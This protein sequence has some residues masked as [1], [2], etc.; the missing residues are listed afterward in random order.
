MKIEDRTLMVQD[1][2]FPPTSLF[3]VFFILQAWRDNE[4]GW[5]ELAI[6]EKR[7]ES[8]AELRW[9]KEESASDSPL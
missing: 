5:Q 2:S 7:K 4:D 9:D 8:C 1:S 3:A 6:W